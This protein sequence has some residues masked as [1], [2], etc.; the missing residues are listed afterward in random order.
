MGK[1][2]TLVAGATGIQHTTIAI[3]SR[4]TR[5]VYKSSLGGG[6][7]TWK[8]TLAGTNGRVDNNDANK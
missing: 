7:S 3:D 5:T 6:S 8:A 4:M 1:S 2:K